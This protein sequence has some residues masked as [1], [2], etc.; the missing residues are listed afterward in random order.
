MTFR[1]FQSL[2]SRHPDKALQ[3]RLPGG[4]SVPESFH[5][6]EVGRVRKSFIDCGGAHH[7][8]EWCSIQAWLGGDDDHRLVSGKLA[9]ILAKAS[10][11]LP[12]PD[13]PVEVEYETSLVSQYRMTG[14]QVMGTTV[15]LEL[16]HKHTDCLAKDR[17]G[18]SNEPA[19]GG[20]GCGP[21]CCPETAALS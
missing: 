9:G 8:L 19:A 14:A 10:P 12:N 15:V 7:E 1:E 11:L 18:V 6:T 3:L 20:C 16:A 21:G 2:L 5:V 4:A 13:I 17:C